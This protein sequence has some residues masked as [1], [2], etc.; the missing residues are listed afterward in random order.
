M[1]NKITQEYLERKAEELKVDWRM[2]KAFMLVECRG[3]GF[4]DDGVTPKILFERHV[5]LQRLN[6][7][8]KTNM[9]LKAMKERP[10]LCNKVGGG[11]GAYAI[12]SQKLD[13][14]AKYDRTSALEACSWGIGQV[15]GY[16]WKALGYVSLQAFINEM[17]KGEQEQ[18]DAS[19]KYLQVNGLLDEMQ[20]KD[21]VGLARGYNGKGYKAK[22]YDDKLED[23]VNSL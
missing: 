11:Y 7:N 8:G 2:L 10:D 17:Y 1:P 23:A 9:T 21:Y 20:R 19:I 22:R 13:Q 15:M 4:N 5:F 3:S 16:H 6:A 18:F 12:Q 14:A